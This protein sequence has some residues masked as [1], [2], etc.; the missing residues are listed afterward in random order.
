LPCSEEVEMKNIES[1]EQ[2]IANLPEERQTIIR[3]LRDV[4]R[5]NLP[6]GFKESIGYGMIGYVVP[7]SLYPPGYH[8][9]PSTPLPFISLASQKNHVAVYHMGI[10]SDRKLMDWF[11]N[12]YSK[13]CKYKLDMG[14]SCIR[15]KKMEDI[16]YELIGELATKMSPYDWIDKYESMFK[17]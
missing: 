11:V 4:I 15:F 9:D 17:K 12:E 3:K 8:A 2:Y 16:P 1:V 13:H 5:Q 10:Y 14:K 6:A 7:H